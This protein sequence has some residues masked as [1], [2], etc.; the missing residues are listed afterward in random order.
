MKDEEYKEARALLEELDS[1][2]K[3]ADNTKA[4]ISSFEKNGGSMKVYG[5]TGEDRYEIVLNS[6]LAAKAMGEVLKMQIDGIKKIRG[7][8][9][10]IIDNLI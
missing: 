6:D 4:M 5:N 10:N 8:L 9:N 2:S 3:S 7:K 1:L